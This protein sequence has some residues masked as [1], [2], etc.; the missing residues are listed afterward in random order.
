MYLYNHNNF[1]FNYLLIGTLWLEYNVYLCVS[2][3]FLSYNYES[4]YFPPI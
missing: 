1:E 4:V 3:Y 2:Y